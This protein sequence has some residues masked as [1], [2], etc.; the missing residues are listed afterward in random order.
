MGT[1]AGGVGSMHLCS[2]RVQRPPSVA[3]EL[4]V[5]SA[6]RMQWPV[7][8]RKMGPPDAA[9]TCRE[10]AAVLHEAA[11]QLLGVAAALD[12]GALTTREFKPP[13]CSSESKRR[14]RTFGGL[15]PVRALSPV[16]AAPS[17]PRGS[18]PVRF[19]G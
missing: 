13:A 3:A 15:S 10:A 9:V 12:S 18:P 4:L 6:L 19:T 1:H 14:R 16:G 11:S 2:A 8:R 7:D 5:S 17:I